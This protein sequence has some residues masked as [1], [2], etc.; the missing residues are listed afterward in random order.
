MKTSASKSIKTHEQTYLSLT[1]CFFACL[2]YLIVCFFAASLPASSFVALVCH[3]A[4]TARGGWPGEPLWIVSV[5]IDTVCL[6]VC[7]FG[8]LFVC[9]FGCTYGCIQKYVCI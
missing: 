9:L 5:C 1:A 8:W 4:Q 7:L 3:E 2:D 6:F